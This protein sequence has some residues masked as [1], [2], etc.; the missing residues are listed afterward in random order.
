MTRALIVVDVQHDFIDGTLAVP[1]AA[2]II[3]PLKALLADA[4]AN[5][6]LIVATADWHPSSHCSFV[7][8][9]GT[10]P[11]HCEAGTH[12]AALHPVVA[13]A[14][15]VL[16]FKGCYPNLEAYSGFAGTLLL[17]TLRDH[18]VT[19]VTI[20]GL[21]TDYCVKATALDAIKHGFKVKLALDACRGVNEKTTEAALR[22]IRDA[23]RE[24]RAA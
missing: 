13:D 15:Q 14:A 2:E 21:A 23:A 18:D 1:G 5:G 20:A 4:E 19:D 24:R 9:G 17:E 8:N 16:A 12:G 6:D 10:W 22:E 11:R 7:D 3:E